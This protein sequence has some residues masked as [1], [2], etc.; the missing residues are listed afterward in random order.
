MLS[1]TVRS[2]WARNLVR[3]AYDLHVH[4]APD[5]MRLLGHRCPARPLLR[6]DAYSTRLGLVPPAR[7]ETR[8][9]ADAALAGTSARSSPPTPISRSRTWASTTSSRWP[10]RGVPGTLFLPAVHGHVRLG[11]HGRQYQGHRAQRRRS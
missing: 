3:G 5:V 4:V 8:A 9:V 7:L 6:W 10:G 11:P 1:S 2:E